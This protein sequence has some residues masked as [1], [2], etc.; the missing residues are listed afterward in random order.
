MCSFAD[1]APLLDALAQSIYGTSN[2]AGASLTTDEARVMQ[3]RERLV[4]YDPFYCQGQSKMLLKQMGSHKHF[5]AIRTALFPDLK[6][7]S[8]CP[9]MHRFTNVRM[10]E[11]THAQAHMYTSHMHACTHAYMY[12]YMHSIL[13]ACTHLRSHACK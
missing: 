2:D 6:S 1:V 3:L 4:I 11:C 10:H 12:A 9:C 7:H 5:A 8:L 13:H